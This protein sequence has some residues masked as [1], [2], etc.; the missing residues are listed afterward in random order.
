MTDYLGVIVGVG[1]VGKRHASVMAKRYPRLL[2]ID[3]NDSALGWASKEL[4][5]DVRCARSLAEVADEV[6]T[7][8]ERVTAVIAT[9]GP[10]HFED[11]S[12]LVDLG[13]RRVFCEKPVATSLQDLRAIRTL[14]SR[15]KVAFTAGLHLRYRG[16]ADFIKASAVSHLGGAPTSFV[17]DGGARCMSTTGSHWLDF[18]ADVFNSPPLDV[19]ASLGEAPINPRSPALYY[20]AGTASWSFS[21]SRRLT[22]SYDN[23]SSV[24][25]RVRLYAPHGIVE[26]DPEL[27]IRL[28]VRN[29]EELSRDPRVVRVGDVLPEPVAVFRPDMSEV[30]SQQLDELEGLRPPLYGAGVSLDSAEALVAAFESS[31]LGRRLTL[32]ATDDLV[33]Q[34]IEWS[35]S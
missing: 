31:R 22:I 35:I 28:L 6:R 29:K 2:V 14:C 8:A 1:S 5:T 3:I 9:W 12:R 32:P 15:K 10:Q 19:V 7:N 17:V 24:H 20:W 11:F 25:E 18:A 27:T 30:L 16:M 4:S 21:G 23:S 26:I 13:V 33:S 34:S